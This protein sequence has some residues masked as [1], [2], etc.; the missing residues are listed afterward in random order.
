MKAFLSY[1]GSRPSVPWLKV[2]FIVSSVA[3]QTNVFGVGFKALR[4]AVMGIQ[5]NRGYI[6]YGGREFPS[7]NR[8]ERDLGFGNS[9]EWSTYSRFLTWNCVCQNF[10]CGGCL[11]SLLSK[12]A[13]TQH[14]EINIYA[15]FR[16]RMWDF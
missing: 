6:V 1:S 2:S 8:N 9:L 13:K 7:K 5:E 3:V 14:S 16:Q 11:K 10:L 12:T 15:G 4:D